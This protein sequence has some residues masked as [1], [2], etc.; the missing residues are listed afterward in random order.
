MS[1]STDEGLVFTRRQLYERVWST[2]MSRLGPELGLS[3]VGLRKL[4]ERLDIPTPPVGYW[5]KRQHGKSPRRPRLPATPD[6]DEPAVTFFPPAG[7]QAHGMRRQDRV[8]PSAAPGAWNPRH[9][10]NARSLW[11]SEPV[12]LA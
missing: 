7:G 3:D 2:P 1:T 6:P 9:R 12:A 8:R 5:A 11:G 4:C 10:T